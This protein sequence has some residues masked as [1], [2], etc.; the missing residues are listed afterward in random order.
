MRFNRYGISIPIEPRRY[1]NRDPFSPFVW[2]VDKKTLLE[3]YNKR[4][5]YLHKI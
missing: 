4:L 3:E 2:S 5:N 1:V